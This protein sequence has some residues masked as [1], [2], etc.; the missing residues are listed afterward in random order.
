MDQD[1]IRTEGI[2]ALGF[3]PLTARGAAIG[4]FMTYYE[5]PHV[6]SLHEID[7]AVT[8]ARQVGF[9][10]ERSM[11]EDARRV[12]EQELRES[13]ER[14]RL[15]AEHAPV[16]IW[17]SRSDGSCLHLNSML[18]N[19]WNVPEGT[20]SEFDWRDT[21]H[22]DDADAI[23]AQMAGALAERRPVSLKGRYRDAKGGWRVLQTDARP[24]F[25]AN[26]DFFGMIGVNVDITERERAD[27][28][29]KLLLDE[30][31]HRVK[32]T[33]AVVQA[34][35]HQTFKGGEPERARRAFEGRIAAMAAAHN[36]LT[37]ENWE[38]HHSLE[39]LRKR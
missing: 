30:L 14:F 23:V 21:M 33:L 22:P 20:L 38:G 11:A 5:A 31:N 27:A 37:Q 8:I 35:A 9:S 10:I 16:M 39:L 18:R 19:F 4:K 17:M 1:T 29:R 24:R 25:A 26:G 13:E 7:L 12:V 2:R 6:F 32:N 34:I 36:L 3:I 28:Q 15:M